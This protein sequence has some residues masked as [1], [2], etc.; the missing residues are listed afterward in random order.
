MPI[1][2]EQGQE[3]FS[4]LTFEQR[5]GLEH[6][7]IRKLER[8]GGEVPARGDLAHVDYVWLIRERARE[9]KKRHD[10]AMDEMVTVNADDSY[11]LNG[12]VS[13]G[14]SLEL[15][16]DEHFQ[17]L[18]FCTGDEVAFFSWTEVPRLVA[19]IKDLAEKL[20]PERDRSPSEEGPEGP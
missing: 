13:H 9:A 3:L 10:A 1:T 14:G 8:F 7:L 18:G 17:A 19:L 2:K 11:T 4:E 15:W 16:V 5:Y 6:D 12:K 20:K